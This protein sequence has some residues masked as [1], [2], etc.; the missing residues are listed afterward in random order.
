MISFKNGNDNDN[1]PSHCYLIKKEDNNPFWL[2]ND[3][4]FTALAGYDDAISCKRVDSLENI[5][6]LGK[7]K[8]CCTNV[9][10]HQICHCLTN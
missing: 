6:P 10:R 1:K 8:S 9:N 5:L 2:T 4:I 7:V 3:H